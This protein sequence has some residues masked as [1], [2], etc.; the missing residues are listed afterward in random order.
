M[1]K[2]VTVTI[3]DATLDNSLIN[4]FIENSYVWEFVNPVI[5]YCV[6]FPLTS[7]EAIYSGFNVL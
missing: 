1:F 7:R 4:A 5:T 6:T 2:V 3:D